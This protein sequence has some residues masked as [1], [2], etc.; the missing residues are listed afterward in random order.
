[1]RPATSVMPAGKSSVRIDEWRRL[2]KSRLG[3]HKDTKGNAARQ[4]FFKA[5]TNLLAKKAIGVWEDLAWR[6]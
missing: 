4:A 5:K 2:F 6:S 3:E 1:V